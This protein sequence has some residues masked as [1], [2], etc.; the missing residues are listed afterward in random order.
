V[1]NM[2][3][4]NVEDLV[5]ATVTGGRHLCGMIL[6]MEITLKDG[7]VLMLKPCDEKCMDIEVVE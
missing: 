2:A 7:T 5:G 4:V 6:E 3:I 1:K